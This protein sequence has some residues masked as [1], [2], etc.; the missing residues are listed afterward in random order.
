MKVASKAH[1]L[2]R[3]N[4]GTQKAAA[5][6]IIQRYCPRVTKSYLS[7]WKTSYQGLL[8]QI[9]LFFSVRALSSFSHV[10]YGNMP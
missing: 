2:H 9:S 7:A 3:D 4:D 10:N 1:L 6:Q 8:Y 5:A